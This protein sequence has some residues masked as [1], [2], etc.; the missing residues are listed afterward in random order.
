MMENF[1]CYFCGGELVWDNDENLEA[2]GGEEDD[3]GVVTFWHCK[4]CGRDYEIAD[5]PKEERET[6]YRDYW[7][8]DNKR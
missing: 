2:I 7:R 6:S 4:C 1:Y 5:P 8:K 3:E